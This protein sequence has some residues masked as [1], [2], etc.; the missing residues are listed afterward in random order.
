MI[1]KAFT[2]LQ[3]KTAKTNSTN[4][5]IQY[6]LV[7]VF[8]NLARIRRV[9][10]KHIDSLARLFRNTLSYEPSLLYLWEIAENPFPL[11]Q[12]C[13]IFNKYF[14]KRDK[15]LLFLNI[16]FLV[17]Q[18]K[19]FN[20]LSSLEI[21]KIVDLLYLEISLYEQVLDI[22]EGKS[23]QFTLNAEIFF[24]NLDTRI[25]QNDLVFSNDKNADISLNSY[26]IVAL[27]ILNNIFVS[28]NYQEKDS[29]KEALIYPNTFVLLSDKKHQANTSSKDL[30]FNFD[31]AF[32]LKLYQRK[33]NK[34]CFSYLYSDKEV[35]LNIQFNGLKTTISRLSG[36]YLLNGKKARKHEALAL[37]DLI[38]TDNKSYGI[39]FISGEFQQQE[40]PV[41]DYI[42]YDSDDK[43]AII[44]SNNSNNTPAKPLAQLTFNVKENQSFF[45]IT[46]LTDQLELFI[47]KKK[48]SAGNV[49]FINDIIQYKEINY[50][51]NK[52]LQLEELKQFIHNIQVHELYHEFKNGQKVALDN[53]NFD[54]NSKE[55]LA[56][57]GPSGSGK[58]TFLKC[59]LGEIT[60]KR[61]NIT[62]NDKPYKPQLS[63][64]RQSIA[65]VPQDDLLFENLTI[66]QKLY[67]CAKIRVPQLFSNSSA[68][69]EK[70]MHILSLMGLWDKR[71]LRAGSVMQKTLSGGERKRLNIALE[72]LSDPQI[73]ILD[74]PTS[75]LSSKDSEK[76]IETLNDLKQI[77]KIILATIHQP[78][79]ELFQ[80]FD[81]LLLLDK[82]GIQVYFGKTSGIFSY[83]DAE[84][85]QLNDDKLQL[86]KDLSMPEF[87]FDILEYSQASSAAQISK[88]SIKERLFSPLYWK[89]KYRNNKMLEFL[90]YHHK[91]SED[92]HI[93]AQID[94]KKQKSNLKQQTKKNYFLFIR[95]LI[96]K[97]AN[98]SYLAISLL[99]A[100]LLG[101]L[102]SFI[103]RYVNND[104]VPTYSFYHNPNII[105]F[106]FISIIV[107]IF[108]GMAS[109]VN[110]IISERRI[111]NRERKINVYLI[112]F[113]TAKF[114]YLALLVLIQ[115]ALYLLFSLPVLQIKGIFLQYLI[116]LFLSGLTGVSIGLFLSSLF[117]SRDSATNLMP[118][119]LIPQIL[120]A[121]AVISFAELNPHVK[122]SDNRSVPEFCDI[123]SSRWLFEGL[124]IAQVEKNYWDKKVDLLNEKIIQTPSYNEKNKL[125]SEKNSFLKSNSN[126]SFKNEKLDKWV[127]FQNGK[128]ANT[129]YY[130][131]MSSTRQVF[132]T[133]VSV[134]NYN[135]IVSIIIILSFN[136]LALILLKYRKE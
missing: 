41:T 112:E 9:E 99:A 54:L 62:I 50:L 47:N 87:L 116:H 60:P 57:M 2:K 30:P 107:F 64:Y 129:G 13:Q 134:V 32:F 6:A 16:I 63:T 106:I 25:L 94:A 97:L 111:L 15:V 45:S 11:R 82:G 42:L 36:Y 39:N 22:I 88:S 98:F 91:E 51:L 48:I 20:V 29:H 123:V 59:L 10:K 72:L 66:Y 77:G 96:N 125:Y 56:I 40:I 33:Q 95:N 104:E 37:D 108:L 75:G 101:L 17:Y 53:I 7:S 84:L 58:T 105:L 122:F 74:E 49:L 78:N 5:E 4:K 43:L 117:Q 71:N 110:E 55:M 135:I 120:F 21:I 38:Q 131:F 119:L 19:D 79:A 70:I 14:I 44:E 23:K 26:K 90:Q 121:G 93:D 114:I 128:A 18:E 65:Y 31:K 28:S 12:S 113:F 127:F 92:Q 115:S 76:L 85:D 3:N 1:K 124:A 89:E 130:Q 61:M 35:E 103:L 81:K 133:K 102:I 68:L 67:Y 46:P 52:Y 132:T 86:K 83:F 8:M 27:N 80:Q 118:Y 69:H 109:S 126:K 34:S 136:G 73:I 100:P 24:E